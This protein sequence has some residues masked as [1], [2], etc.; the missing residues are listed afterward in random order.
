MLH[1]TIRADLATAV[2]SLTD[3]QI[4]TIEALI[5]KTRTATVEFNKSQKSMPWEVRCYGQGAGVVARGMP[6]HFSTEDDAE[7]A[8]TTWIRSGTPVSQQV[9]L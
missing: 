1:E 4:A 5:T 3:R 8:K 7:Q 6:S 2:P 9:S